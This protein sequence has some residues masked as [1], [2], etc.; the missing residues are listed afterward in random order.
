MDNSLS[1]PLTDTHAY[2]VSLPLTLP[3][4][5][6]P[7]R[8]ALRL[9]L[10]ELKAERELG[11]AHFLRS[12]CFCL[13]SALLMRL[14]QRARALQ[15]SGCCAKKNK[16][17]CKQVALRCAQLCVLMQIQAP[18]Q[19]PDLLPVFTCGLLQTGVALLCLFPGLFGGP[20]PD[21]HNLF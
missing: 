19:Q 1:L 13:L 16:R 14:H 5:L 12:A 8:C 10:A 2:K 7:W 11:S 20:P 9:E 4:S 17:D 3:R 18:A 15:M 6:S 21:P